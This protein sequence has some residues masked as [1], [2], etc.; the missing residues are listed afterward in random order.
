MKEQTAGLYARRL[1]EQGFVTLA[2][3]AA[4]Q[5]ES[6]GTP[7]WPGGPGP[8]GRGHQGRGVVPEPR[9]TRSTPTASGRWASAP[10]A[11]TSLSAAA[12]DHRDQGRR[13]PSAPST[14][15]ASSGWAPTARRTPP[16]SRACSTRPPTRVPPRPAARACQS[17]QLFPDTAEQARA[18]GGRHAFDGFEYY[19][20]D[21]APA[22]ALGEVLHLVQH[23]PDGRLRRLR[24][25]RPD[26]AAP[27]AD[28]RRTRGG[29]L[30]DERRGVPEGPRARRNSTGSTAP[31]TSTCTTRSEYVHARGRAAGR[32]LP[33]PAG[34]D[35]RER[36]PLRGPHTADAGADGSL[37]SASAV[38]GRPGAVPAGSCD[39]MCP[40]AAAVGLHHCRWA[41]PFT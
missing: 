37:R 40:L 5:G 13:A 22:P 41:P 28:D 26:L 16:S 20:T 33:H 19:C 3:D 32:L 14:S 9:A 24:L 39:R 18:M 29:D 35:V 4:Y 25:R 6:E 31:A 2:F 7:R 8:P 15:P 23:R 10:P 11:G 30:L 36:R 34:L 38:D 27:A 17:F 21:R 1:A 12:T